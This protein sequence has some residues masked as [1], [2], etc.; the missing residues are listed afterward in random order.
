MKLG[1]LNRF[2]ENTEE[3]LLQKGKVF[4]LMGPRRVGKTELIKKLI[5]KLDELYSLLPDGGSI[6]KQWRAEMV[7]LG[8]NV[9]IDCGKEKIKGIAQDVSRDGSLL[10]R[11]EGGQLK[12]ILAGD[13][14]LCEI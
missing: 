4:V 9:K 10:L 8:K 1:W 14:S 11:C 12:K 2:Y 3:K 6:F 7:M 13:V 5:I